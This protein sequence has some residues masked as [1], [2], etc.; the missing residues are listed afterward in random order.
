M[1]KLIIFE[2]L[3]AQI[4]IDNKNSNNNLSEGLD[5]VDN[6]S[7]KA[8]KTNFFKEILILRNKNLIM[9]Q[10][11]NIKYCPTSPN[12]TWQKILKKLNPKFFKILLIAPE[13]NKIFFKVSKK[14]FTLGFT[15]LNSSLETIKIFS[16]KKQTFLKLKKHNI[17]CVDTYSNIKQI[18]NKNDKILVK[19]EY[20]AG[21]EKVLFFENIQNLKKN[22]CKSNDKKIFQ[23]LKSN[24]TGS[25]SMLCFKGDNYV[26]TCNKQIIKIKKNRIKQIGVLIGGFEE[27]RKEFKFLANKISKNFP[28]LYGMIG[29]DVIFEENCWKII[30]INPRITSSFTG[31]NRAYEKKTI[32]EILNFY[33]NEKFCVLTEPV[34]KK[35]INF[36]FK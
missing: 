5:M 10:Y 12:L 16:S 18:K 24:F 20:G 23:Y 4:K 6:F 3:S 17:P 15:L 13:T 29:V 25:F 31:I 27:F 26:I 22:I 19:P 2:Y 32:N 21:S 7:R 36:L 28:G 1:Q 11:N 35:P 30:E 9:N 33:K 14:I 34:M 8:S